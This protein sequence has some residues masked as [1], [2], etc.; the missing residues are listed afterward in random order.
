MWPFKSEI[1]TMYSVFRE[2]KKVKHK[3]ITQRMGEQN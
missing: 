3:T 2:Y 1:V